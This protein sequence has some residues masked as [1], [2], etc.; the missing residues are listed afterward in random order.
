MKKL[1]VCMLTFSLILISGCGGSNE[2]SNETENKERFVGN[3]NVYIIKDTET[4]CEYIKSGGY[5]S[6]TYLHGSCPEVI[7]KESNNN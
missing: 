5:S 1:I 6:W 4:G 7:A 2:P 3:D